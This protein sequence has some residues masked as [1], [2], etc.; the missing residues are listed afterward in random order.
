MGNTATGLEL[1]DRAASFSER[2]ALVGRERWS[3]SQLLERSAAGAAVLSTE[4]G[5]SGDLD[6]RRIA[7]LVTPSE[8]YVFAQWSIW[9]AGGIAVPLCVSHPVPELEYVLRD[10][11]A[12]LVLYSLDLADQAKAAAELADV[13]ALPVSAL[14][15]APSAETAAEA[16][17]ISALGPE[18]RAMIIYTS[19]T[20]GKPKGVVSTHGN[21]KA[22]IEALVEAWGWSK[23]DH[24]LSVLPLHHL[25]GI[26]NV[27]CCALWSGACLE[28]A[29]GFD[30]DAVWQRFADGELTVFMAV[31][32]IYS[33]LLKA[34]AQADA[35][36][37]ETQSMG[38]RRMRLMVSGSAALPVAVLERWQVVSGHRLLERY[39]MSETG[40]ILSNPLDGERVAG[41]VGQPVPGME[42]RFVGGGEVEDGVRRGELE[43]RGPAVFH[44]YWRR[45]VETDKAFVDGWFRTGDMAVLS[46]DRYR[47]LGRTSVDILKSGGYKISALEI[48]EVLRDHPAIAEVAVVGVAD[49]EWGQRVAA[50]V[51]VAQDQILELDELREWGKERL[52]P[53][54]VPTL[55]EVVESLPRNALG[56]VTKPQVVELFGAAR[57]GWSPSA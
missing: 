35:Q 54:K 44:E 11:D 25:H 2:T 47:L 18:R 28:I 14:S 24:I 9:R 22:Q 55:L 37:R 26:V 13:P 12:S 29:P 10:S 33:R 49:E 45:P 50:A 43:V 21:L 16:P 46:D 7:F 53:Y 30:A 20:T 52:A 23:Q 31:P 1:L 32:T 41:S 4:T 40:M 6:E 19:G 17:G 34:H 36:N 15:D 8:D 48:E 27:G 39:G 57:D 42:V 51:V 56:K 5:M 38:A 3:Y